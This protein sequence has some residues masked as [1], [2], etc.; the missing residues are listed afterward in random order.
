M[1]YNNEIIGIFDLADGR[2]KKRA[3]EHFIYLY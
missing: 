2:V 1:N 3:V